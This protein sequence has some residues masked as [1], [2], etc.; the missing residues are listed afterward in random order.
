M[1]PGSVYEI[2]AAETAI[3][4]ANGDTK[5]RV[6]T[7]RLDARCVSPECRARPVMDDGGRIHRPRGQRM[8]RIIAALVAASALLL[9]ACSPAGD[10]GR[11]EAVLPEDAPVVAFYGDSYTLGTGASDSSL[12]WS[13]RICEE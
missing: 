12:R 9:G 2:R 10:T 4:T 5:H 7:S 11:P 3:V 13:T 8:R 6:C 1:E